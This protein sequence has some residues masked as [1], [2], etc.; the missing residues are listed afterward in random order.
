MSVKVQ[1]GAK[2]QIVLL[3]ERQRATIWLMRK[4]HTRGIPITHRL[5]LATR[6][7]I[8]NGGERHHP[9]RSRWRGGIVRRQ[10]E[11]I[12]QRGGGLQGDGDTPGILH[13]CGQS[14]AH[15]QGCGGVAIIVKKPHGRL[16]G[17]RK[18]TVRGTILDRPQSPVGCVVQGTQQILAAVPDAG[19]RSRSDQH[20][21]GGAV[22]QPHQIPGHIP[23]GFIQFI[24]GNQSRLPPCQG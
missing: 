18:G 22:R 9:A 21:A 12:H 10:G 6:R 2:R 11:R 7:H 3:V 15:T 16:R 8:Q 1:P 19:K 14:G 24:G 4:N 20:P 23:T 5:Q 17:H 13:R